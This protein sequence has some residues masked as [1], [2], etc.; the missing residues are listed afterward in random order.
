MS[1]RFLAIC[2]GAALALTSYA[3]MAQTDQTAV[4]AATGL[5][6]PAQTAKQSLQSQKSYLRNKTN[7]AKA[8]AENARKKMQN[9]R[10]MTSKPAGALKPMA[11]PAEVVKP[12]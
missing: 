6:N 7:K 10:K 12:Q 9:A 4:P 2:F 8:S 3:V 5:T 1:K 11:N